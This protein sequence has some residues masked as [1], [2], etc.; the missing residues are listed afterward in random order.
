MS[1]WKYICLEQSAQLNQKL[2]T[3][4]VNFWDVE[5]RNAF[6][7]VWPQNGQH[8]IGILIGEGKRGGIFL[9]VLANVDDDFVHLDV[10]IGIIM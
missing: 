8:F 10:I 7:I 9:W 6:E 5:E 3:F 1:I 4:G 2:E